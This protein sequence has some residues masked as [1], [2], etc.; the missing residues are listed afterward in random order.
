MYFSKATFF[1]TYYQYVI[2]ILKPL[3]KTI[4]TLDTLCISFKKKQL[5]I[6]IKYSRNCE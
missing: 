5:I 6:V 3:N 1:V 4:K 2:M